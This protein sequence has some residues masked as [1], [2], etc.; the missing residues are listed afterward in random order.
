[1]EKFNDSKQILRNKLDS[2][3]NNASDAA[4]PG[5]GG[6]VAHLSALEGT[7]DDEPAMPLNMNL[8]ILT[9]KTAEQIRNKRKALKIGTVEGDLQKEASA[10]ESGCDLGEPSMVSPRQERSVN[11][12][13]TVHEWRHCLAE[14]IERQ[15][16][17]SPVLRNAYTRLREIWEKERNNRSELIK[18]VDRYIYTILNAALKNKR[19]LCPRKLADA[20]INDDLAYLEPTRKPPDAVDVKQLYEALWGRTGPTNLELPSELERASELSLNS[21]FMPVTIEEIEGKI[22]RMRSKIAAGPDGLL[23]ENLLM[24]SLPVILAKLF[25]ILWSSSYFPTARKENR[26]TLI[27]KANKNGNMVENWRPIT[28]SPIL[29]R[30]FSSILDGRL[31]RGVDQSSRQ[32]GFISESGCKI[33]I[34]LL[35]AALNYSKRNRGGV[36]TIVDTPKTFDTIPHSAIKPCLARKAVPTPIMEL[37][38]E[39]YNGNKTTIKPNNNK[40]VEVEILRGAKQGDPLSPLLFNLCLEPLLETNEKNTGDININEANKVSVLAFA[41][42]NVLLGEDEREAITKK[43]TWLIKDPAVKVDNERI[44]GINPD[45]AFRYLGATVGPWKGVHCGIIMPEILSMVRRVRKLSLKPYQKIELL[46][47]YIFPRYIHNLLIN[48]PSEGVLKLMD[49]EV[50]QEIKAILHLLPSIATGRFE[51]IVKLANLE[52]VEKAKRRLKAE[53]IKEWAGLKSQG[54]G[55]ADF[56]KKKR[57]HAQPESLAHVLGLCQFTK[58]LRIKRHDEV[59]DLLANKLREQNEVFV[60]PTVIVRVKEKVDKYSSCLKELKKRYGVGNGA[61]LPAVLGSRGAITPETVN[62]FK[63]MGIP[64]KDTKTIVLNVLRSSVEMCNLFLDE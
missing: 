26:T 9:T 39:M 49:K 50:R 45:Q 33:N 52:D 34:E 36:F 37:I 63:M 21:Y 30:I 28:V 15:A 27:P 61:V 64:N 35:N 3:N 24:P 59:K 31:R 5:P 13:E 7:V 40:G 4:S 44:S 6:A 42:D 1:M 19:D 8:K 57:C 29:G 18:L 23:K 46:T 20:I 16:E 60:K 54:Q 38:S 47:K 2:N 55:V 58:S 56:A 11:S 53:H 41:D 51:H 48:P 32:K 62:N 25:N 14:E 10:T 12:E 22:K 43:D 17:V